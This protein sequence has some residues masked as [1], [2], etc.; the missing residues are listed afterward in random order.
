[1]IVVCVSEI[2]HTYFHFSQMDAFQVHA[3]KEPSVQ[4]SQMA[5]GN[6]ENAPQDTLAMESTARISMRCSALL[7]RDA[8]ILKS[9]LILNAVGSKNLILIVFSLRYSV[10]RSLMPALNL[11]E[12]T[13]VRTQY[14]ATTACLAPHAT[15]AHSRLVEEWR[16]LLPRNR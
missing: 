16:M 4:A 7:F 6:V 9:W 15:M 11:M 2:N 10:R 5:L 12:S 3:L 14:Q 8:L 1:M 13:G